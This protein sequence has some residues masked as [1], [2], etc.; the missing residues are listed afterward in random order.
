MAAC[1]L[2]FSICYESANS[3]IKRFLK[4]NGT[5]KAESSVMYFDQLI[6][7]AWKMGHISADVLTWR[8]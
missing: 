5:N 8:N 3:A 4:E 6:R 7:E 1:I 2:S